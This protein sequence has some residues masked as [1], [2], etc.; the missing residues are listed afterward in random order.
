MNIDDDGQTRGQNHI[1]RTIDV[2][3]IGGIEN[4]RIGCICEQR[5]RFDWKAHMVET[6]R[7]DQRNI[8][9]SGMSLEMR[10]RVIRRLRKPVTQIDSA[11][12]T[13]ESRREIHGFFACLT[14]V[15]ATFDT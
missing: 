8:L 5:R 9:G 6:H 2:L 15:L 10:F 13:P 12:Q 7:F 14:V 3:Q 11:P 1:E 4:R